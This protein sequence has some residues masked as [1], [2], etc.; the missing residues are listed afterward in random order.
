MIKNISI[1]DQSSTLVSQLV[2]LWRASVTATHDFLT[3]KE[4]AAIAEEVPMALKSIPTLLVILDQQQQPQAFLGLVGTEIAMLFVAPVM[5]G[6]GLGRQL[7]TIACQQY[8][9]KQLT[10]NEQNPQARGFYEHLGFQVTER[11]KLDDQGRPYPI[12]VM[13]KQ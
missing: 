4:I 7:I 9:A 2:K 3:T 8:D 13:T 10:V 6:Q 11:R 5:R 1:T 12:L